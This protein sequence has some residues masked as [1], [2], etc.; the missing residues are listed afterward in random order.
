MITQ[1]KVRNGSLTLTIGAFEY[2]ASCQ[3]TSV[4]VEPKSDP[5]DTIEALCGARVGGAVTRK[6]VLNFTALQDFADLDGLVAFTWL[7]RDETA[8]FS[9]DPGTGDPWTGSTTVQALDVGGDVGDDKQLE[10]EA[11][12]DILDYTLPTAYSSRQSGIDSSID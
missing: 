1:S 11:Q 7:H 10:S 4:K 8:Q 5:G 3:I 2:D 6:D 9:W 12:W